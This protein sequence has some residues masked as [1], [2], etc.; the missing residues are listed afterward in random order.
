MLDY[1]ESMQFG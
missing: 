1:E